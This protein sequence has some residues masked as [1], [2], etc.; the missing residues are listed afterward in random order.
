[1]MDRKRGTLR[2]HWAGTAGSAWDKKSQDTVPT[3]SALLAPRLASN[4]VLTYSVYTPHL[5]NWLLVIDTWQES[6]IER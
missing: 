4:E 1:M 2:P 5:G 6:C 3:A